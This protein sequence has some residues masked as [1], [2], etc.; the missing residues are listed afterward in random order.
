MVNQPMDILAARKRAAQ[1]ALDLLP[2]VGVIGLGTGATASLFIEGVAQA[3]ASGKKRLTGVATSEQSRNLATSLGIPL[4]DDDGP[5]DIALCVDGADEVSEDLD[6]IKGGGGA[7][8]REKIVNAS[9]RFNVIVVDEAKLSRHLGERQVVPIEVARFGHVGTAAHLAQ[10][11][12]VS[13][14]LKEGEPW[15]TDSGNFI[16]DLNAGVIE[17]PRSLEQVLTLIPGV[18]ATGLFVARTDLLLVGT[19]DGVRRIR[20]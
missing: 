19:A 6:L 13:Q 11:G 7:H 16:Y 18:V 20:R 1:A 4:H 2:D 5:W 10:W 17:A 14:R 15:V 8:M 12:T 3:L 9:S